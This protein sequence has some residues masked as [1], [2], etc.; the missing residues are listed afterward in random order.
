MAA[1]IGNRTRL[2]AALLFVAALGAAAGQL[3]LIPGA[4]RAAPACSAP[5]QQPLTVAAVRGV[6]TKWLSLTRDRRNSIQPDLAHLPLREWVKDLETAGVNLAEINLEPARKLA[7]QPTLSPGD[8]D[9]TIEAIYTPESARSA[10]QRARI[11][12]YQ[13]DIAPHWNYTPEQRDTVLLDFLRRIESLRQ[14]GEIAGTVRFIIHQRLWFRAGFR[15]RLIERRQRRVE[16]FADD[17]AGFIRRLDQACLGHWIAG[18][19]LGEHSNDDMNELLPLIVELARAVNARTGGWLRSHLFVVNGGGW[20]AEYRGIDHVVG[21][22]GR[23]FPFLPD[24]AAEAGGFAFAYKFEQFRPGRF[25]FGITEHMASAAC[26]AGRQCDPNAVG[27]WEQ[28]LGNSLG[29]NELAAYLNA[30]RRQYPA[31][32][33]VVFT[34]DTTDA[35]TKMVRPG[36]NGRLADY[37]ALA[38]LRHLFLKAGSVATEGKIFMNGYS[39]AE[40]MRNY[41]SEGAIDV[42]RSLYFVNTSGAARPLPQSERIWQGWPR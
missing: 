25:A 20:G 38:A 36:S 37:P 33:H 17:M 28:Y 41:R 8:L 35:V 39:T 27:D 6:R 5:R 13:N 19:R 1:P 23:T 16:E 3:C 40:T 42:G 29:F 10:D 4:A 31:V 12:A 2:G 26:T 34:G 15:P 11:A 22:D 14:K 21:P 9:K 30:N 32:A 24:I 7:S 18:V